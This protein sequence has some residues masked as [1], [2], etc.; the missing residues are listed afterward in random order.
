[1]LS[2][3]TPFICI[4]FSVSLCMMTH[5]Y[6]A[7]RICWT[8]SNCE[9]EPAAGTHDLWSSLNKSQ[10]QCAKRVQCITTEFWMMVRS[11]GRLPTGGAARP[12]YQSPQN[13]MWNNVSTSNEARN[14]VKNSDKFIL[15]STPIEWKLGRW[16]NA[17]IN[18]QA[19]YLHAKLTYIKLM[20]SWG[21]LLFSRIYLLQKDA[22]AW[23]KVGGQKQ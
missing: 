22:K 11:A 18:S 23:R 19:T 13:V 1:M 15:M 8:L 9:L 20:H 3:C 14:K 10:E 16:Y 12:K 2:T 5:A 7:S 21:K 4:L 17:A 6:Y